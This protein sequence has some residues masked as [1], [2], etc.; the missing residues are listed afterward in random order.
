MSGVNQF[1][2][3]KGFVAPSVPPPYQALLEVAK[4]K[5]IDFN[6]GMDNLDALQTRENVLPGGDTRAQKEFEDHY[7]AQAKELADQ[8]AAG[9]MADDELMY[10]SR[11]L[12]SQRVRDPEYIQRMN[13]Y[14]K[15][16][17]ADATQA[18][19]AK[20]GKLFPEDNNVTYSNMEWDTKGNGVFSANPSAS[21]D[22]DFRSEWQDVPLSRFLGYNEDGTRRMGMDPDALKS[23]IPLAAKNM[24]NS[25]SG[26]QYINRSRASFP[27]YAKMSNYEIAS[28]LQAQ[29]AQG[30]QG[31]DVDPARESSYV[32]KDYR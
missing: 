31:V 24:I 26:M 4:Q 9:Q 1:Y 21:V 16:Q 29:H 25:V 14:K 28:D 12:A 20:E 23:R 8:H 17:E 30:L 15:A 3:Y 13:S 6:A 5:R 7:M 32:D 18:S 22:Y 11:R 2:D 19:L 27:K 10:K